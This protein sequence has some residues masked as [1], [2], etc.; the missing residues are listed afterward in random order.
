[1][2]S[3]RYTATVDA[4]YA[5]IS[6]TKHSK[7]ALWPGGVVAQSSSTCTQV[8]VRLRA[9]RCRLPLL[10]APPPTLRIKRGIRPPGGLLPRR[11]H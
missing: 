4:A 11:I 1:M 9:F 3:G 8:T 7:I 10:S 5:Q 2:V 6:T